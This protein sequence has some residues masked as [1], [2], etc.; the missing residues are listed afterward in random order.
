MNAPNANPLP[1]PLNRMRVEK[2][3]IDYN[4]HMNDAYYA[5]VFSRS[6]DKM[7]EALG[8][9]THSRTRESLTIYTLTLTVHYLREALEG[10]M[11]AVEGRVLDHDAKRLRVWMSM[12]RENG[13]EC[14]QSEQVLLCVDQSGDKPR[15]APFPPE[16]LAHLQAAQRAQADEP[17]P[18]AAGRGI[19]LQKRS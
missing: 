1:C 14:A 18:A 6:L 4:G 2:A 5:L 3:W 11:L 15:G 8:L 10:E 13:E 17:V 7:M 12:K 9:A 16:V 19:S